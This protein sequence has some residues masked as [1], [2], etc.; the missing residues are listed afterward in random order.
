MTKRQ[1]KALEPFLKAA[2]QAS[3]LWVCWQDDADIFPGLHH[4]SLAQHRELLR[5]FGMLADEES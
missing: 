1:I 2:E 4:L 3:S 5:A